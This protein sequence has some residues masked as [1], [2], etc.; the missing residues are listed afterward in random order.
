MSEWQGPWGQGT[1]AAPA[2]VCPK[3]RR[4][5]VDGLV[6]F[7]GREVCL[8]CAVL[9]TLSASRPRRPLMAPRPARVTVLAS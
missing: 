3:C 8:G 1:V 9:L 7:Q 5:A 4:E 2:S 6:V